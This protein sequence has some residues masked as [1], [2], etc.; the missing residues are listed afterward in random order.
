MKNRHVPPLPPKD[1]GMTDIRQGGYPTC[2]RGGLTA[3]GTQIPASTLDI[4]PDGRTRGLI[5]RPVGDRRSLETTGDAYSGVADDPRA[6]SRT[7]TVDERKGSNSS[8]GSGKSKRKPAPLGL[9]PVGDHS[10]L[11]RRQFGRQRSITALREKIHQRMERKASLEGDASGPGLIGDQKAVPTITTTMPSAG[12]SALHMGPTRSSTVDTANTFGRPPTMLRSIPK[13]GNT[14][15]QCTA[16]S[17]SHV[18]E[19]ASSQS[20]ATTGRHPIPVPGPVSRSPTNKSIA[21]STASSSLPWTKPST[22]GTTTESVSVVKPAHADQPS[23][24]RTATLPP[25][26]SNTHIQG[27]SSM[28]EDAVSTEMKHVSRTSL[29]I[30]A[31][32]TV[33]RTPSGSKLQKPRKADTKSPSPRSTSPIRSD[34][35]SKPNEDAVSGSKPSRNASVRGGLKPE[36]TLEAGGR[37]P[38]TL[39][40]R[41]SPS[42]SPIPISPSSPISPP[43]RPQSADTISVIQSS[44]RSSLAPLNRQASVR[45]TRSARTAMG[46]RFDLEKRYSTSSS[47]TDTDCAERE[48]L[49]SPDTNH[50]TSRSA[51][52]RIPG[53][54]WH[55][56]F[57]GT[58]RTKSKGN[59][60]I[61]E[62]TSAST[63]SPAFEDYGNLRSGLEL[64]MAD[65][66]DEIEAARPESFASQSTISS[67]REKS[68]KTS[69]QREYEIEK[70]GVVGERA[71]LPKRAASIA[72]E[73][74]PV[75]RKEAPVLGGQYI[76]GGHEGNWKK[77]HVRRASSVSIDPRQSGGHR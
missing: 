9:S 20:Q 51:G 24:R 42:P 43:P 14:I 37:S 34:I 7:D 11:E 48:S 12:L 63:S 15:S 54:K 74:K 29:Q 4:T 38:N 68:A 16:P 13:R 25:V 5:A 17:R 35:P 49:L 60:P 28:K 61:S 8:I 62:A 31:A 19:R 64:E 10:H 67:M 57:P 55:V 27:Q 53:T 69:D 56:P 39:K 3:T 40:K 77:G 52:F 76:D 2:A 73:T 50:S 18:P 21:E 66:E 75:S 1:E 23:R 26:R 33:T 30:P 72:I 32:A 44:L 45:S 58:P 47:E 71:G 46:V 41:P 70:K 59:R 22:E 6:P 65:L 36:S